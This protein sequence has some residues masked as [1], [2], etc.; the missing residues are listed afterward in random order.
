MN[1]QLDKTSFVEDDMHKQTVLQM[2]GSRMIS[3]DTVLKTI[4]LDAKDEQK[5]ILQEQQDMAEESLK[6]QNAQ[7]EM[8]MTGSV[9]PPPGSVG[10]GAAQYNMEMVQQQNMPQDPAAAG[11]PMPPGAPAAPAGAGMPPMP[12]GTQNSRSAGV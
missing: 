4:G 9:L 1:V 12:A 2:A 8:E 3:N 7:Q 5:K 11:Q 6:T 10:I